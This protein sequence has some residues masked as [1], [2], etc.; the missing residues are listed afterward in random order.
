[1]DVLLVMFKSDGAR[2]DFEVTKNRVIIGRK[3][4][5]DLRIPLSSVSRHHCEL[6]VDPESEEVELRD[7]G[8]SNG[9]F[10][11]NVRVQEAIV[12]AG[13]EITVGP[14]IFTVV[15]DGQPEQVKPIR[16]VISSHDSKSDSKSTQIADDGRPLTP[17]GD[18]DDDADNP[19]S[20]MDE[21][22]SHIPT[23]D[24]DED[25]IEALQRMADAEDDDDDFYPNLDDD[26][27]EP[28]PSRS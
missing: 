9:T 20:P 7:L 10:H 6:K 15:I 19:L 3:N 22:D 18:D 2:R 28:T 23:S 24:I 5:C 14:V 11:N 16:T 26:D 1:M 8:S 21:D 27:D 17:M 4:D 13:D 12:S 25:P